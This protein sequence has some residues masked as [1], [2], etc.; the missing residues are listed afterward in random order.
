MIQTVDDIDGDVDETE[1]DETTT[2]NVD[3]IIGEI[4]E[5]NIKKRSRSVTGISEKVDTMKLHDDAN[6]NVVEEVTAVPSVK[7]NDKNGNIIT[8]NASAP[9]TKCTKSRPISNLIKKL[10]PGATNTNTLP[11]KLPSA[12]DSNEQFTQGDELNQIKFR[13]AA[14][15]HRSLTVSSTQ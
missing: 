12:I 7:T 13:R 14:N 1:D 9:S 8:S 5:K 6:G 2:D 3:E 10:T 11:A 15:H 4:Q